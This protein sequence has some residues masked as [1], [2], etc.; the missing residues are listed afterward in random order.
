MV[1]QMDVFSNMFN[2]FVRQLYVTFKLT[3][4]KRQFHHINIHM[5]Y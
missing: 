4:L 5:Y 3:S 1:P 2:T